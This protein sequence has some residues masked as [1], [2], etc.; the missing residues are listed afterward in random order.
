MDCCTS[1]AVELL[2]LVEPFW[3]E[4]QEGVNSNAPDD[5]YLEDLLRVASIIR[6]KLTEEQ[7]RRLDLIYTD[8][9]VIFRMLAPVGMPL[10]F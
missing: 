8:A 7:N 6:H 1:L 9:S 5:E 4:I 2:D 10:S 3:S